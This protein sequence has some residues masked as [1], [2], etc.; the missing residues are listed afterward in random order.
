MLFDDI[1]ELF[2]KLLS[3]PIERFELIHA[4]NRQKI[5]FNAGNGGII[6]KGLTVHTDTRQIVLLFAEVDN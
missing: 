1:D 5:F 2:T 4:N 3:N 6:N